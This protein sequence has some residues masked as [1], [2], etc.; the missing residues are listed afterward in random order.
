M[1][2]R[3]PLTNKMTR[4]AWALLG[5]G[6]IY[7]ADICNGLLPRDECQS[8]AAAPRTLLKLSYLAK[9]AREIALAISGRRSS[10]PRARLQYVPACPSS[11]ILIVV[12]PSSL[13]HPSRN[14]SMRLV[15]QFVSAAG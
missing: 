12:R 13:R 1:L 4:V 14:R 2:P 5:K 6:R 15:R 8:R 9:C 10:P 7:S 11:Q 3:K